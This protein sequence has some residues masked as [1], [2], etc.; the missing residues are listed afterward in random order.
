MES[1]FPEEEKFS[2]L[3]D[4]TSDPD[5]LDNVSKDLADDVN[6]TY[7]TPEELPML[8]EGL[9]PD[10]VSFFH[11]NCRSLQNKLSDLQILL[12]SCNPCWN[13]CPHG[14]MVE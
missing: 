10:H 11:V 14:N 6:T 2:F 5:N 4:S 12:K 7:V 1:L 9:S 3:F 8:T 13:N